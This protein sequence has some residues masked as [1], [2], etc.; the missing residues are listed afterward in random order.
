MLLAVVTPSHHCG[1]QH[2]CTSH[3]SFSRQFFVNLIYG[4]LTVNAM[5]VG[6]FPLLFVF[7]ST[8]FVL[9]LWSHHF[10][11]YFIALCKFSLSLHPEASQDLTLAVF[12]HCS[13]VHSLPRHKHLL[14]ALYEIPL[15]CV[16][17]SVTCCV[18]VCVSRLYT[19]D[20]GFYIKL[21]INQCN[22]A[23]YW[24]QCLLL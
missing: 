11:G 9:L 13:C 7:I 5:S 17:N 14:I 2:F 20:P 23:L 18:M 1:Q 21:L 10:Y 19:E 3:D 8:F 16:L 22:P 12:H 15:S 4:N 24:K 6:S